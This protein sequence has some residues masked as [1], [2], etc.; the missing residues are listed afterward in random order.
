MHLYTGAVLTDG[1]GK[2]LGTKG[3]L[4]SALKSVQQA[5]QLANG[6]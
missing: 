2:V 4:P 6:I 3:F 5:C 1:V